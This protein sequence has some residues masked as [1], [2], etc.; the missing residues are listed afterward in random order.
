M[1]AV[2][3]RVGIDTGPESGGILGP[4]YR[5]GSFEFV[6]IKDGFD[7]DERT[8]SNTGGRHG[9]PLIDYFP[10]SMRER[11]R[12][13]SMHVDPEFETY[14]YGD[15]TIP[16]AS[17]RKLTGGDLLVFYAG[18]KGY[19]FHSPPALFIV[20]YFEVAFAGLTTNF[21][22]AT[23]RAVFGANFHVRHPGV[24]ADQRERLLLVKGGP[25]SRLLDRPR[26]ISAHGKDVN[27][28]R[29]H[30]LSTEMRGV[31]GDF[32]GRVAIQRSPP[33]WVESSYSDSAAAFVRS[34]R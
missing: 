19:D 29:L 10:A 31:F 15:P 12:N 14:T 21:D 24:F 1:R 33:R 8:Y 11:M 6:P 17:L 27:G 3:L 18:L 5:D 30:V 16:K 34:L 9:K 25:G 22:D 32:S 23:I 13:Q 28:A 26:K 4:L 20:G 7:L 2:L